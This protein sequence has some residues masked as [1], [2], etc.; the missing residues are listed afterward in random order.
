MLF[1][2]RRNQTV[3]GLF[4]ELGKNWIQLGTAAMLPGLDTVR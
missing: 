2:V 4:S 1:R 3:A